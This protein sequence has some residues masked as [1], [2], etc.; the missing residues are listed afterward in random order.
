ML[1]AEKRQKDKK[2]AKRLIFI[3]D[4]EIDLL[5]RALSVLI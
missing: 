5:L 1:S 4:V 3:K 2:K